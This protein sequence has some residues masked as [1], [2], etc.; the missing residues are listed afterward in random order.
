[1]SAEGVT[2]FSWFIL[3]LLLLN[4]CTVIA[5][6]RQ[7]TCIILPANSIIY[8]S[9]L[10]CIRRLKHLSDPL[11]LILSTVCIT[12]TRYNFSSRSYAHRHVTT[13][14]QPIT[15]MGLSRHDTSIS[16][17]YLSHLTASETKPSVRRSLSIDQES[18]QTPCRYV[19]LCRRVK[20]S[21]HQVW[22]NESF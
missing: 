8:Y 4:N 20:A 9:D 15:W 10:T 21:K 5:G 11:A 2:C 14:S 6:H 17:M 22:L 3:G 1:M 7:T 12:L 18:Y 16:M 19:F 13:H